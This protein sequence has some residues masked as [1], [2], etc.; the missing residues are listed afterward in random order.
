MKLTNR[1]LA[2]MCA[3]AVALVNTR[4]LESR[5]GNHTGRLQSSRNQDGAASAGVR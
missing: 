1:K 3:V 2:V 4:C 5:A